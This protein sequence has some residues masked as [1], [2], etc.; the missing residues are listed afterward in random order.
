MRQTSTPNLITP[1]PRKLHLRKAGWLRVAT[2]GS[3]QTIPVTNL[4][5]W[6]IN[7][8]ILCPY[9]LKYRLDMLERPRADLAFCPRN[10]VEDTT[11]LTVCPS[12]AAQDENRKL[13]L[14]RIQTR[15]NI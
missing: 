11:S 3:T 2:H 8:V 13:S 1:F 10:Q 5:I 14:T 6:T 9:T 7:K 12:F 15:K 4:P